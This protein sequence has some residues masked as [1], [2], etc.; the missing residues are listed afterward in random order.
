MQIRKKTC[1]STIFVLMFLFSQTSVILAADKSHIGD[2]CTND[3]TN[4]D[5]EL[6]GADLDCEGSQKLNIH[7][8][9]LKY[10]DCSTAADCDAEYGTPTTGAWECSDGADYTYNLDY[11]Y[12]TATKEVKIPA[13][14][15]QSAT[16]VGNLVGA[17]FDSPASQA[18]L[19]EE[20][21]TFTPKTEIAI[22]GVEFSNLASTTDEEGYLNIPWIGEY[23]VGTYTYVL[24]IAAIL[25]AIMIII[26]GVQWTLS[27]GNSSTIGS[28]KKRIGGALIGLL[29][30]YLS[31]AVL[32][33]INPSLVG[34]K[35]LKVKY[36]E[37]IVLDNPGE[38]TDEMTAD[39][40]GSSG[41]ITQRTY[42]PSNINDFCFPVQDFSENR[43]N[44]GQNRKKLKCHSGL[45]LK[46]K[47]QEKKGTIVAMT[48]GVVTGISKNYTKCSDGP[49]GLTGV[50]TEESAG[51]VYVYDPI[52]D[53][54][55]IYGEINNDSISVTNNQ[56]ISKGTKL[57]V[58][59]K[60]Q[61][62]HL[63]IYKGKG[64]KK[65]TSS[66]ST[67]IEGVKYTEGWILFDQFKTSPT[68]VLPPGPHACTSPRFIKI[69]DDLGSTLLDP[70]ELIRSIQNKSC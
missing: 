50:G 7:G 43:N 19:L 18:A 53:V 15:N 23:I 31:Y 69:L 25:A 70:T 13:G 37:R 56:K 38:G 65:G 29:I 2:V 16:P 39:S 26:G 20:V 14:I 54:T 11:C 12:N 32:N 66:K 24:G 6:G 44:W 4:A 67:I 57:G 68:E 59:T 62:L 48:D 60:C 49:S 61:M 10:C 41:P 3:A 35:S 30:A 34:L 52:N 45:D 27:G 47:W 9:T 55:Y 40:G 28:A 8:D 17:I 5:C 42:M 46:T 58:A 21:K 63:E 22:P 36:T 1:L 51:A 33:T 64:V